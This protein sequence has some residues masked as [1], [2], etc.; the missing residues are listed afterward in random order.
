MGIVESPENGFGL[1]GAGIVRRA[2]A[3]VTDLKAGDRVMFMSNCTFATHRVMPETLCEG[4]PSELSFEDAA[5]MPCVFA[6][7]IYS[8]FNVGNLQKGQVRIH[9]AFCVS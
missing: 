6:T 3:N 7:S 5:T 9:L 4:I 1:E 8:I 2:G